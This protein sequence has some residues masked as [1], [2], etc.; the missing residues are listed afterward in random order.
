MI[1][2]CGES[3]QKL[4]QKLFVAIGLFVAYEM[5]KESSGNFGGFRNILMY[6]LVF[7]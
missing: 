2:K 5:T 4:D 3:K 7:E 1:C 6:G